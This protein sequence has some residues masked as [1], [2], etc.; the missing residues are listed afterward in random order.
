M[1]KVFL[2]SLAFVLLLTGPASVQAQVDARMFRYP[3]VS[4]THICFV[5]A[6]DIWVVAKQGGTAYRLSSPRGE[7]MFPRFSPDGSKIAF[8]ANY[9]G[10]TDIYFI[11][12]MGGEVSRLTHHGMT[13]LIL[14]W[15]PD[16][17]GLLYVSSMASGRQRYNQFYRLS[18]DGGLPEKLPVPYGEFGS[19]S[20]DGRTLAYMPIARDFRTWKRYRGG[21]APDIWLFDLAG[22]TAKNITNNIAND[23]QPM[24]YGDTLYFLSDRGPNQRYNIWALDLKTNETRQVTHLEDFDIHFPAIGPSDIVFEAGGKL[25]L[26][27]LETEKQTQVDIEV[28]TDRI[29]LRSRTVNVSG[30]VANAWLSPQGKRALFEARGEIFTVPAEHG[31]V[32]NLT[33]SPGSAERY[34]AWSPDGKS[35]AYWSDSSGEYE[36]TVCDANDGSDKQTLTSYGPGYRYQIFWSPDSGKIAFVDQT[37]TIRI[38]DRDTKETLRIDQGLWM[39]EGT[40]RN[41]KPDWSP[42]SRWLVY[43]RGDEN[44]LENIY[45]YDTKE[46]K[47]HQL[48]S[49]FYSDFLPA[50]DPDGNYLY[51]LSNRTFSPIYADTDNSFIY[52]NTT[53]VVA[54][55][56]KSDIPSPLAPRNDEEEVK[57]EK[58]AEKEAGQKK[59]EEKEK[60]TDQETAKAVEIEVKDFERRLVVLPPQAGNYNFLCAVPGKVLYIRYPRTGSGDSKN[61][62][63][64]YDLKE[65]K[66]ETVVDDV[67]GFRLSADGKKALVWKRQDAAIVD[68]KPQQNLQKRLRTNELEMVV[69]PPAEWAQIFNDAWRLCRDFFYDK[70]MHG[71]D[72]K[73]MRSQYGA[74]LED[75]VTRWDVNYIIG[76]LIAE[77]SSSH[78]YRGGGDAESADSVNVGYLG[79][80]WELDHGAYR[81]ARIIDSASFESEVRSPLNMPGVKVKE[82]D[83]ILAVNGIPLETSKDPWAAFQGLAGRTVELTVNSKPDTEGAWKVIVQTLRDE[84]RLRHLAWIEENRKY[85]EDLSGGRIGYIY[86]EDTSIGGQNM[87]VRQFSAQF[88]KEGLIIDERFNSGGQIPDRFIELLNRPALAFW[89]VRDGKDWQWPPWGHFGPKAML[90]NGWSGSGGDAFPDYFRKAGLGP[91]IGTRTW[92]GLIGMSGIPSLIDG[93]GVTVPTFRMYDPDGKWF[94]EG[95][96]VD[97]D[98]EVKEDPALLVKGTDPQIQRAVDEVLR[99]IEE[100][101]PARPPRPAYEDRT[102]KKKVIK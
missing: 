4:A 7:E 83:C 76:E 65:R 80:D 15:Y 90:I 99:K 42:D 2:W 102:A 52:A 101:G 88:H 51:F 6:G 30:L 66:E 92:G 93:G 81:I 62:L 39:T 28:V 18:P 87:L 8:S 85:V 43:S 44:R 12:F 45:L 5:Y 60:E 72:W 14:D 38:F 24:W 19:V 49:G 36:L 47:R 78:T 29:T 54:V 32:R 64:Y 25:Y 63:V 1:K 96:G 100:Q 46:N 48:T 31:P 50:F 98:I 11:P 56:L 20:P 75:A 74:L 53:N 82:G 34:P 79:V 16:G 70:G 67:D 13:D 95:H 61:A 59:E 35:V 84:T 73:A 27:D 68:I 69:D 33:A 55:S 89:A 58:P 22:K 3:D 41:F 86:V 57:K 10:N 91:L 94:K 37:M 40:L 77:L 23:S 97:P 71:V 26:L 9:D 17:R 21:M